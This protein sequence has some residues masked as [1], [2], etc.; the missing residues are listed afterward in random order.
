MESLDFFIE[1]AKSHKFLNHPEF[2]KIS[3]DRVKF[4][5]KIDEIIQSDLQD[6][7]KEQSK[8][9]EFINSEKNGAKLRIPLQIVVKGTDPIE[10]FIF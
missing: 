7:F 10:V 3:Y 1:K 5:Q 9:T 4:I 6:Y 8:T 2:V